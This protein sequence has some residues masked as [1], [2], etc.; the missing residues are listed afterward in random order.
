MPDNMN[1][2]LFDLPDREKYLLTSRT[3]V[4]TALIDLSR[5]PE[6]VAA[7]FH[8]GHESIITTVVAVLPERNLMLL[9]CGPDTRHNE[10][11]LADDNA[12]CLSKHH[13]IDIRF[14][15][16]T[17]R[18][19]RYRG[20]SVFAAPIPETVLRLQRREFFRVHAPLMN[21]ITCRFENETTGILELP[22][23]DISVGGLSMI[24]IAHRF[25]GEEKM[26]LGLCTLTFP[27]N[28]G[29]MEVTLEVRGILLHGKH[30]AQLIR[31]IGC[32]YTDLSTDKENFMQRYIHHLQIQQKNLTRS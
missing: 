4:I 30:E 21:P 7:Y 17:L 8:Q 23:A 19:A 28:G 14:Q 29:D 24:D 3:D 5:K 32:A 9:E 15:L 11:L 27:D 10:R 1:S 16:N 12:T 6:L 13:E 2:P 31:R 25:S 26:R 22:L 18:I 20:E